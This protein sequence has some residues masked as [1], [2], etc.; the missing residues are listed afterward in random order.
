MSLLFIQ[1]R[2]QSSFLAYVLYTNHLF[3]HS[4]TQFS[5]FAFMLCLNVAPWHIPM[6]LLID[7]QMVLKEQF[8]SPDIKVLINTLALNY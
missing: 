1:E 7:V 4:L 5:F 3:T 8:I 6:P 2:K